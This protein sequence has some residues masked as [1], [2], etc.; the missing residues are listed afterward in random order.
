MLHSCLDGTGQN[1]LGLEELCTG[2]KD[3]QKI[4]RV[5]Q[6]P[7]CVEI[8]CGTCSVHAIG[9]DRPNRRVSAWCIETAGF[10]CVR[11]CAGARVRVHLFDLVLFSMSLEVSKY[12]S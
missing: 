5:L 11:V 12:G 2:R 8:K 7:R 4:G 10:A 9:A 1:I 3:F 6:R